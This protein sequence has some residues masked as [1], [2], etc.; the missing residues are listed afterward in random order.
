MS[1]VRW[2]EKYKKKI[3][4]SKNAIKKIKRGTRIFL[5]TGCGVPY[6]LVQELANHADQMS[7]NEIV[8]LLTLGDTPSA[9]PKFQTQFRHNTFFVSENIRDAV[10]EGRADYSPIMLSDI[11]RLFRTKRMPLDVALIQISAP[12][13]SLLTSPSPLLRVLIW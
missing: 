11:P 1:G 10:S 2:D 9:D 4:P 7:D 8:H 5:G 12:W 3:L 6:H 13:E